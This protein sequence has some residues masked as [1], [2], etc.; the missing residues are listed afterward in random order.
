MHWTRC[1]LVCCFYPVS[2]GTCPKDGRGIGQSIELHAHGNKAWP[3]LGHLLTFFY[4]HNGFQLFLELFLWA[5]QGKGL[6]SWK[7][8]F[9][10]Q[11]KLWILI[12]RQWKCYPK[13]VSELVTAHTV[14]KRTPLPKVSIVRSLSSHLVVTDK[15]ERILEGSFLHHQWR[16]HTH[17]QRA[18]RDA[19]SFWDSSTW[20]TVC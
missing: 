2:L 13:T 7:N 9:D 20:L 3:N 19:N 10:I 15:E 11:L 1:A 4:R 14:R 5:Q 18:T 16:K 12:W 17:M 8:A 6:A